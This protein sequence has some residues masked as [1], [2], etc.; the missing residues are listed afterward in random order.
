MLGPLKKVSSLYYLDAAFCF[1][2]SPQL[3]IL[4]MLTLIH[5]SQTYYR[6]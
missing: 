5:K 4:N 2:F 3:L 6:V 1:S